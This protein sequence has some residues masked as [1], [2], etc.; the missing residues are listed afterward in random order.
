MAD[1]PKP[2]DPKPAEQTVPYARF[3]EVVAERNAA[4]AE[5]KGWQERAASATTLAA[6]LER[7]RADLVAKEAAWTEERGLYAVGLTDPEGVEIARYLHGRLPAEGRPKLADWISGVAKEPATA[8]KALLSYLPGAAPAVAGAPGAA[9]A[10][11]PHP[12][13]SA[14]AVVQPPAP[15]AEI[16]A[17]QVRAAREA[18]QRGDWKPYEAL[19]PHLGLRLVGK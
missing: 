4:Q 5:V 15:P 14:G 3:A 7:T 10:K 8:P 13:G 11:A 19:R 1:D 2:P 9:P 18:G 12:V 17:E 6:E 16:T